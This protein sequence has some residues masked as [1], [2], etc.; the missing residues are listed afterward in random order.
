[1][2]QITTLSYCDRTDK[3]RDGGLAW[4]FTS[5]GSVRW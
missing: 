4:I 1:M 3:Y 5:Q 2:R